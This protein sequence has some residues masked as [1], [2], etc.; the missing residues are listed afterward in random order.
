MVRTEMRHDSSGYKEGHLFQAINL[1]RDVFGRCEK[2]G[3]N[4]INDEVGGE[5]LEMVLCCKYLQ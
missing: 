2:E 3:T 5:I 4:T 1:L